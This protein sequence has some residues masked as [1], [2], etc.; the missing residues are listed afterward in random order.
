MS[1]AASS[2][3]AETECPGMSLPHPLAQPHTLPG[4]GAEERRA[5]PW[6]AK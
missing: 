4:K 1:S 3:R 2:P 5:W 6:L